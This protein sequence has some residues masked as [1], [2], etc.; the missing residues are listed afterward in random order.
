MGDQHREALV[1]AIVH[2]QR[3]IG[4][5]MRATSEKDWLALDLTLSQLKALMVLGDGGALAVSGLAATLG[6]KS[7]AASILVEGLV[8]LGLVSRHEDPS[9][10]RR[11]LV[12]LTPHGTDFVA[13]LRQ[14]GE[15]GFR[16]LLQGLDDDDL[17]ALAR[18]VLALVALV[19][20]R[21][22]ASVGCSIAHG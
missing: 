1:D 4:R 14:G 3:Q 18:G 9:D 8:R 22:S 13:R 19:H 17:A 11:A 6:I 7:S 12:A 5:T 21:Q 2:A 20:S 16:A 10:R 15:E